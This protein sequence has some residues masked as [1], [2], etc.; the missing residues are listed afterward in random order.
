M[1]GDEI[2]TLIDQLYASPQSVIDKAI[3]A[4]D[5]SHIKE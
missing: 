5:T 4:S 2:H 3:A 1:T